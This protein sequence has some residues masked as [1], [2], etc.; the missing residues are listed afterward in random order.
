MGGFVLASGE[1]DAYDWRG[2]RVVIKA[3]GEATHGQLC[4]MEFRYPPDLT[5]PTH[6]H[7]GEDEMF[8]LLEGELRGLCDDDPWTALPGSFV[9]VP[10]DRPHSLS[11]VGGEPA[12]GIV[13]TGP[14]VLYRSVVANGVPVVGP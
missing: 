3:S 13:V 9:F 6:V 12:R 5:V 10:R 2:A 4:V 14:A 11:V 1:G 7:D 8:Y